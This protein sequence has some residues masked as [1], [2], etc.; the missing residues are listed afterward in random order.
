MQS[1]ASATYVHDHVLRAILGGIWGKE[2]FWD[3]N[4]YT[5]EFK[6][7]L[8]DAWKAENMNVVAFLTD[9]DSNSRYFR[10]VMNAA[11]TGVN[12]TSSA[13]TEKNLTDELLVEAINGMVHITGDYQAYRIYDM[14]GMQ[15]ENY[16]LRSGLYLVS[17]ETAKQTVVKKIVVN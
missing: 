5:I 14:R 11:Q 1:G 12:G 8:D 9:E 13:I 4:N 2:V 16:K 10:N 3:G 15:V 6:T 7:I 17:I